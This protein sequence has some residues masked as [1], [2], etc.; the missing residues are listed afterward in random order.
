MNIL[1]AMPKV[2]I[3]ILTKN[4]AELLRK[5][6]ASIEAQ[7]FKDYQ[8]ILV[9]DGST[10]GTDQVL[11]GY[12]DTRM[13]VIN[14]AQS[15]G[16]TASRQEALR[17]SAGEFVVILDD[18][19][20]WTDIDKLAKQVKY[21]DNHQDYVLVGG[22]IKTS[23]GIKFRPE[24][25]EKIRKTM[26]FRNNFF[27]STVMFRREAAVKAGGFII[28]KDDFAEDYDLWLRMGKLG[29]MHNFRQVFASYRLPQYNKLK[30]QS[31]FAKQLRLI[32]REKAYYPYYFFARILLKARAFLSF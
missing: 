5:A 16:I 1:N 24:T 15:Q 26:L 18:D 8:I 4:R 23:A 14:H 12:R 3:N 10:D 29:Q 27:T 21:L 7:T 17:Q 20:E 28:D 6:L 2:S 25:E 30:K 19:D 32:Y 13:Q 22:A 31:F 11:Q 9:D